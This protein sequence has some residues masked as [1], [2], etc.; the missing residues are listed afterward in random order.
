MSYG[1]L[2]AMGRVIPPSLMLSTTR[3]TWTKQV[4]SENLTSYW[5]TDI[6]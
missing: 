1:A 2:A 5:H 6:L 4:I 3:V